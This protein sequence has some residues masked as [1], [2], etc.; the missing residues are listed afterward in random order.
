MKV[1]KRIRTPG[2]QLGTL[3]RGSVFSFVNDPPND[4]YR[5]VCKP[6]TGDKID[7]PDSRVSYVDLSTGQKYI[8]WAGVA[9]V[10]HPD[11][12]LLV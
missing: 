8:Y 6:Y 9:I 11:A 3:P 2:A 10:H 4:G 1:T 7:D 5:M 12:E